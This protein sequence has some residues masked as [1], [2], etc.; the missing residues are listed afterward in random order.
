MS[1]LG[2]PLTISVVLW[3]M[4]VPGAACGP[5]WGLSAEGRSCGE[6]QGPAS[7]L[8]QGLGATQ[9]SGLGQRAAA[10]EAGWG[11]YT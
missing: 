6:S 7:S 1:Y 3:P 10:L 4:V 8:Q 2:Q 5:G 9:T 11:C